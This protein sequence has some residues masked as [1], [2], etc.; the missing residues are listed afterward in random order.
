[1]LLVIYIWKDLP[2]SK[3]LI[4]RYGLIVFGVRCHQYD[5]KARHTVLISDNFPRHIKK[6]GNIKIKIHNYSCWLLGE[7][8]LLYQPRDFSLRPC[9]IPVDRKKQIKIISME[10]SNWRILKETFRDSSILYCLMA[11]AW[12]LMGCVNDFVSR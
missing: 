6:D 9:L 7:M 8:Q 1:M 4:T 5:L 10:G 11:A 3:W 12:C 2:I